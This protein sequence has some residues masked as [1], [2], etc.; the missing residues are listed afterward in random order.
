MNIEIERLADTAE[1]ALNGRFDAHETE[2]FLA[3]AQDL[4]H[5]DVRRIRVELSQVSFIDSAGL[6]ELVRLMKHA[7]QL[8]GDVD[9]IRPSDPVRV[10][11]E[12]TRLDAAFHIVHDPVS[13]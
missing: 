12:L 4:L 2:A 1:I 9:L 6:A 11:L 8:G 13:I 7:R 10:I 5:D 3:A